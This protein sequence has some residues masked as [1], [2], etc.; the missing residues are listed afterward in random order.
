MPTFTQLITVD[1]NQP[2]DLCPD[3]DY[4]FRIGCERADSEAE[5]FVISQPIGSNVVIGAITT[6][7]PFDHI[8]TIRVDTKGSYEFKYCCRYDA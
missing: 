2:F 6:P 4:S 3:V 1:P 5:V 8:V 7:N